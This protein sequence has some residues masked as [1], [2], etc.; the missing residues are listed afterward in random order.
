MRHFVADFETT[1][2]EKEKTRIWAYGLTEIGNTEFFR[3]GRTMEGFL[4]FCEQQGTSTIYFHNLKFDGEFIIHYLLTH[5]YTHSNEKEDKTFNVMISKMNQFYSIEIIFK[6][7]GKRYKKVKF[8]DSAKKLPFPVKKIAEDF[9]MP[10]QKL[11]IDY[12]LPRPEGYIATREEIQYIRND[13]EIVARALEIQYQ[14]GLTKMTMGSDA[15][16]YFKNMLGKQVWKRYFPVMSYEIDS[17]K[18]NG[19]RVSYRGGFTYLNPKYKN[20]DVG[21]G[22]VLDVN[23][24]YPYV[25][26]SKL[27]PYDYPI[28]FKGQYKPNKICPLYIQ[29]FICEF[30]I[31][32]NHIPTIQI[33]KG[34]LSFI[35]TE[36]IESSNYEPVE[37]VLTSVDMQLFFDHYDVEIYEYIEGW[38]F[39]GIEGVFCDY[40]DYWM[41]IKETSTGSVRQIAKLML[42]SLYGKFA[43]NPD[44]TGKYPKLDIETNTVTYHEKEREI[45]TPVYT[46]LASFVTAYAREI[47]IR[48]AQKNYDRFIYADT[49]SLHL[50]GVELPELDIHP[51]KLGAWKNEG[52][53]EKGRFL[54]A[55]SYVEQV[56][57]KLHVT[58]AGMPDNVKKMVIWENF[59]PLNESML[60]PCRDGYFFGKLMPKRVQGGVILEPN[61]FR[62]K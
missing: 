56:D 54:R 61:E 34:N 1:T 22:I 45:T 11:D 24:L 29:R 14:Q 52:T 15:L 38:M 12:D 62:I 20:K 35:P 5:G 33:K 39:R 40:I 27:L 46:P 32:E 13:V 43:S 3:A 60:L 30:K 2:H 53:F 21:E 57:G 9:K 10:I 51:T 23:S 7:W 8:L 28:F 58:C 49:D 42:N 18:Q 47:T 17:N 16:H 19:M 36:Y 50:E 37:L 31:K 48:S 6:R 41:K 26:Y 4:K 44:V 55:K 25:M 59:K